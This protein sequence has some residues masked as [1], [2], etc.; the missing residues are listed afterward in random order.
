MSVA[1]TDASR[2]L[3]TMASI[4]PVA[5]SSDRT[6]RASRTRINSGSA[7]AIAMTRTTPTNA[8]RRHAWNTTGETASDRRVVT[9]RS[10]SNAAA[11]AATTTHS[12]SSG[13]ARAMA[14]L[15][16][17]SAAKAV[18]TSVVY[19]RTRSNPGT[20]NSDTDS[21]KMIRA[22]AT[23]LGAT[24]G[25]VMPR[26]TRPGDATI[27]PA[28]SRRPS[29]RRSATSVANI[30][31]GYRTRLRTTMAAGRLYVHSDTQSHPRL[32]HASETI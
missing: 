28:S 31:S 23:T 2:R 11:T 30:D 25:R 12:T 16:L 1:P 19:T 24:S 4:E 26:S 14:R 32:T 7:S 22:A 6:P 8:G 13:R 27:S 10:P 18:N 5:P 20:P 15:K 3:F 21:T 29:I 9:S 17:Y